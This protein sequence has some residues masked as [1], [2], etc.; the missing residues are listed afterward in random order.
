MALRFQIIIGAILVLA[1]LLILQQV[2]K[3]KLNLRFALLWLVLGVLMLIIDIFPGIIT[4]VASALG[5]ELASNLLFFLGICFTLILVFG[6]T[7]KVSKLSDEA[8]RLTQEVALLKEASDTIA[9]SETKTRNTDDTTVQRA[10]KAR[11]TDDTTVQ[12]GK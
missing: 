10:T 4:F 11:N 8:K 3:N 5:L 2:R 1:M 12:T 7:L 6:L 9:P